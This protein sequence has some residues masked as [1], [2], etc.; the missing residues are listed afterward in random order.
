MSSA[1]VASIR[2]KVAMAFDNIG[3]KNG[4]ALPPE[5]NLSNMDTM[6]HDAAVAKQIDGM[7]KKRWEAARDELFATFE[8]P[9]VGAGKS[10][11]HSSSLYN[12][13]VEIRNPSLGLDKAKLR[14]NLITVLKM[15]D[16][17][18]DKFILSCTKPRA[19]QRLVEIVGKV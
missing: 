10:C 14:N 11:V 18:A 19:G 9:L 2:S 6:I 7:A 15:T 1:I 12:V 4:H 3:K 8:L 16:E 17:G 5:F 13:N